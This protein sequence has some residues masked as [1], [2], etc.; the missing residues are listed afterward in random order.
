M[1]KKFSIENLCCANCAKKIEK[2]INDLEEVQSATVNFLMKKLVIEA[3]EENFEG[4][5]DKSKE[6]IKKIE[7]DCVLVA[8]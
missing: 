5:I 8:R 6:I 4:I 1:K 2:G 3:P 7:P